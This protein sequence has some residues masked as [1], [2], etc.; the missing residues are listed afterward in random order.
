QRLRPRDLYDV[1]YLFQQK[2]STTNASLIKETLQKKCDHRSIGT[3]NIELIETHNNRKLLESEWT[4][5]LRH[6]ISELPSFDSFLKQLKAVLSW[7]YN[8]SPEEGQKS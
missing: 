7:I 6:Q 2:N 3:P 8:K 5:Q 1:V 4:T